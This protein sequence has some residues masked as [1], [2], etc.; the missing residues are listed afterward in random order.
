MGNVD[1]GGDYD[2]DDY[3]NDD[4]N[5]DSVVESVVVVVVTAVVMMAV[6]VLTCV[7]LSHFRCVWK[8]IFPSLPS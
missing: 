4:R 1:E 6:G 2:D 3:S 8:A 5:N 7:S